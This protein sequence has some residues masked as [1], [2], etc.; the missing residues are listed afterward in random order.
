MNRSAA[1]GDLLLDFSGEMIHFDMDYF[2]RK[3]VIAEFS[4][5]IRVR[6]WRDPSISCD[7]IDIT[8]NGE[9]IQHTPIPG[10]CPGW[11]EWIHFCR[12]YIKFQFWRYLPG[13]DRQYLH[14]GMIP[15]DVMTGKGTRKKA[16][17]RY[18]RRRK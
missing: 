17:I 5:G 16:Y 11:K 4:P 12:G 2:G 7:V 14:E 6:L 10:G 3:E 15:H 13:E 18:V 1:N 8:K 9:M